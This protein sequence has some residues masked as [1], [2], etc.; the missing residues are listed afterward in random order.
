[1]I[2]KSCVKRWHTGAGPRG[3]NGPRVRLPLTPP[4]S[5]TPFFLFFPALQRQVLLLRG[6]GREEHHQQ[7]RLSGRQLS[8]DSPQVQLRQP[9]TGTASRG[10]RPTL[11]GG[12]SVITGHVIT[13]GSLNTT[14]HVINYH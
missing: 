13:A 6:S 11:T 4:P 14:L 8:M 3:K 2:S 1:M 12:G 9:G 10:H 5:P 7:I